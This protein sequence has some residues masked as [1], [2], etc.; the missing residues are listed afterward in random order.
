MVTFVVIVVVIPVAARLFLADIVVRQIALLEGLEHCVCCCADVD[1]A[2][3]VNRAALLLQE[4]HVAL[5]A[6]NVVGGAGVLAALVTY[7]LQNHLE[8]LAKGEI[9]GGVVELPL[10]QGTEVLEIVADGAALTHSPDVAQPL[11]VAAEALPILEDL[12]KRAEGA[13]DLL[14]GL[15]GRCWP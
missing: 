6:A 4:G 13:V 1:E 3:G 14:E 5:V 7:L 9:V 11:E 10:D 15:E 8:L 2:R 12:A